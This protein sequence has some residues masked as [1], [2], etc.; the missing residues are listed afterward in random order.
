[1][2]G[3]GP[4]SLPRRFGENSRERGERS[5]ES[6]SIC[7]QALGL[8]VVAD[9]RLRVH[10]E[11][12]GL[13]TGCSGTSAMTAQRICYAPPTGAASGRRHE[14]RQARRDRPRRLPAALTGDPC[15]R[16]SPS[17][18]PQDACCALICRSG[19]PPFSLRPLARASGL[20][21]AAWRTLLLRA[22]LLP[23]Q[24]IAPARP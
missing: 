2:W 18:K 13:S 11:V 16:P 21:Q 8:A 22:N 24:A 9:E 14:R 12:A 23:P 4:T 19:L 10:C 17:G 7:C 3:S 20:P 15:G 5:A 1:M 6:P